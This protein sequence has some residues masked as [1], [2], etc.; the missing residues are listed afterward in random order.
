MDPFITMIMCVPEVI[1]KL[2]HSTI[3]RQPLLGRTSTRV[4]LPSALY[5]VPRLHEISIC[6]PKPGQ[7]Y[8]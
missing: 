7:N 6:A 2:L 8:K 1:A 5:L 3:T 4:E